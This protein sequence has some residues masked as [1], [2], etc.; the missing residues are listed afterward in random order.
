ME[1]IKSLYK[2]CVVINHGQKIYDGAL[3]VLLSQYQT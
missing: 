1:D 2:R 3:D